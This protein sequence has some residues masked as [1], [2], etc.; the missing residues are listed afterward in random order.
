MI[1]IQD[2]DINEQSPVTTKLMICCSTIEIFKTIPD[3]PFNGTNRQRYFKQGTPVWQGA[4]STYFLRIGGLNSLGVAQTVGMEVGWVRFF[5]Y[6]FTTTDFINDMT[7][8]WKRS[9]W[10]MI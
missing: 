5:D 4:D 2:F 10:N 8:N 7:N 9:W 3:L 6:V 1:I